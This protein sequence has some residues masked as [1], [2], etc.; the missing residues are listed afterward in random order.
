MSV[1]HAQTLGMTELTID[2]V[3]S[4]SAVDSRRYRA[5]HGSKETNY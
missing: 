5:L 1:E 4:R 2:N 3:R